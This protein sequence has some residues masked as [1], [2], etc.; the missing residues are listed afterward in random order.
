ME[1]KTVV[2]IAANKCPAHMASLSVL[3]K[4][5]SQVDSSLL[6]WEIAQIVQSCLKAEVHYMIFPHFAVWKSLF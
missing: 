4:K 2:K 6:C 5:T 3:F 1:K